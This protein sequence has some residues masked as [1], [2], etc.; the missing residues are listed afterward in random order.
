MFAT[1]PLV[2]FLSFS[3]EPLRVPQTRPN[4]NGSDCGSRIADGDKNPVSPLFQEG[5]ASLNRT[6]ALIRLVLKLL[7][8]PPSSFLE[9]RKFGLITLI[10]ATMRLPNAAVPM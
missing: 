2:L 1:S 10:M 8:Q 4:G 9:C 5:L 3:R 7:S 6:Y